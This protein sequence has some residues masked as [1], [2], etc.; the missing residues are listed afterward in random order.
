MISFVNFVKNWQKKNNIYDGTTNV[1][2]FSL[3]N[4]RSKAKFHM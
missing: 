3:E 4:P 1:V 2:P